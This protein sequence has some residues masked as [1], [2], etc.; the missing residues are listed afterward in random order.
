MLIYNLSTR[1]ETWTWEPPFIKDFVIC[2]QLVKNVHWLH[3]TFQH[4]YGEEN[5]IILYG[6]F[7]SMYGHSLIHSPSNIA[8][9]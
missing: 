4:I 9:I 8:L 3:T 1:S 6:H 7:A 5:M 2:I